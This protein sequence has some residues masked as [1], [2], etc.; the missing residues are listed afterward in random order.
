MVDRNMDIDGSLDR[1]WKQFGK[2]TQAGKLLYDLYGVRYRPEKFVN[3]PKLVM[4]SK[5]VTERPTSTTKLKNAVEKI[6]YPELNN[7]KPTVKLN[8]VDLIPKRKK[9]VVIKREIECIKDSMYRANSQNKIGT[10][11]KNQIE[12]LQ[13]KF[14]FQERTVMPK[15]ARLP[16]VKIQNNFDE[17][18]EKPV[19]MTKRDELQYLYSQIIKEIDERYVYMEEIKQLGENKDSIIMGEI[20]DRLDELKKI[21]LMLDEIPK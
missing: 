14:M 10:N 2:Q 8:K 9:E 18:P 13:D 20:K 12:S 3:Y 15:G 19:R 1:V 4:K 5:T 7:Y 16:G 17:I 21:K 6:N 11:R